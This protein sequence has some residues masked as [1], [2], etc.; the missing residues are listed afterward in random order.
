VKL[1]KLLPDNLQKLFFTNVTDKILLDL[2]DS[3][4]DFLVILRLL[5]A[6]RKSVY[7]NKAEK[8]LTAFYAYDE[9]KSTY[10]KDINKFKKEFQ[11]VSADQLDGYLDKII[12]G[13]M[14]KAVDKHKNLVTALQANSEFLIML[15][16][17]LQGRYTK[18]LTLQ[19]D[20]FDIFKMIDLAD[21]LYVIENID[22][23]L[24]AS[25][26]VTPLEYACMLKHDNAYASACLQRLGN[27]I[28]I[29]TAKKDIPFLPKLLAMT[30]ESELILLTNNFSDKELSGAI[31]NASDFAVVYNGTTMI[32]GRD[33][34]FLAEYPLDNLIPLLETQ[35][36]LIMVFYALQEDKKRLLLKKIPDEKFSNLI[37]LDAEF[38]KIVE[39]CSAAVRNAIFDKLSN[40][41][42]IQ[43]FGKTS[44]ILPFLEYLSK[45]KLGTFFDDVLIAIRSGALQDDKHILPVLLERDAEK[46]QYEVKTENEIIKQFIFLIN[47]VQCQFL[48]KTSPV[49]SNAL[50]SREEM[51]INI[52]QLTTVMKEL[53]STDSLGM[54]VTIMSDFFNTVLADDNVKEFSQQLL[55][56]F[57]PL[58]LLTDNQWK[59]F[60]S[61]TPLEEASHILN[62]D[63][64]TLAAEITTRLE[65]LLDLFY[66]PA[67]VYLPISDRRK[68]A[69]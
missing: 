21:G 18:L 12:D 44:A 43:K 2:T 69:G 8:K 62:R 48:A 35:H 56:L 52:H 6:N 41:L 61:Y 9:N 49:N 29:N 67:L 10:L 40:A 30:N 39:P 1:K 63:S 54:A 20:L 64:K 47:Y 23:E 33:I 22:K 66:P 4:H 13:E 60:K 7:F 32:P 3:T 16:H 24:L 53:G 17:L 68:L 27:E 57:S 31:K 42:L 37:I 65:S 11:K 14:Q 46:S 45:Q 51:K 55:E 28:F 36:D 59:S 25:L 50:F 5:P 19:K 34:S 15:Y 58:C 38:L 26:F